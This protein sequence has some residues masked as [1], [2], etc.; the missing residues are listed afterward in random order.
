MAKVDKSVPRYA[1]EN[2]EVLDVYDADTLTVK[3]NL[4]FNIA[5]NVKLRLARINAWEV[6]G[7]EK[8]KGQEAAAYLRTKIGQVREEGNKIHIETFKD[9]Q[10]KFGR[11]LAEL[12]IDGKNINDELV[13]LGFAKYQDYG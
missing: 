12:Y 8:E 5:F 10:E 4:G 1:Y 13:K 11:Y 6:K 7:E 2:V 3:I 9:S